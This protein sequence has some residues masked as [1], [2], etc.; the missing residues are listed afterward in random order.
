MD[1]WGY[2]D[3][4]RSPG[5]QSVVGVVG[6]ALNHN[7]VLCQSGGRGCCGAGIGD[8]VWRGCW[9]LVVNWF[10]VV[11]IVVVAVVVG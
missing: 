8:G 3:E 10:V 2:F 7:M 1:H 4:Q 5:P 6:Y 9:G 11:V